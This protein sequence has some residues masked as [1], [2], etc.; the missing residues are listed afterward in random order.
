METKRPTNAALCKDF[1]RRLTEGFYVVDVDGVPSSKSHT[2]TATKPWRG[3]LWKAFLEL[4]K[5]LCPQP[6]D[7]K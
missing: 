2:L 5:R 4:E 1:R 6:E 3:E 7:F